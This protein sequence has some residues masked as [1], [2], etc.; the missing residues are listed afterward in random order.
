MRP[1]APAET[2]TLLGPTELSLA[3]TNV[4]VVASAVT[5][6]LPVVLGVLLGTGGGALAGLLLA[7]AACPGSA[8]ADALARAAAAASDS[9]LCGGSAC[10]RPDGPPSLPAPLLLTRGLLLPEANVLLPPHAPLAA[11]GGADVGP[12]P[13]SPRRRQ[14]SV[15]YAI[16]APHSLR[17]MESAAPGNPMCNP[18]M[19]L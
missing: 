7:Y 11:S 16:A 1:C 14:I 3:L 9:L 5:T 19:R 10:W 6:P 8:G 18:K 2:G 4:G 12:S 13:T 17:L 15:L